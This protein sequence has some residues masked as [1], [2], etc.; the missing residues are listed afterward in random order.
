M[1]TPELREDDGTYE[2]LQK[3]FAHHKKVQFFKTYWDFNKYP[4]GTVL[5]EATNFAMG[6]CKG[7]FCHYIQGDECLHEMDYSEILNNINL[8]RDPEYKNILGLTYK[9][10]HFYSSGN[11]EKYTRKAY[12]REVR[13]I[14]NDLNITSW[15]DA[16]G[17]RLKNGKKLPSMHTNLRTFHYGWARN[18]HQMN[19]KI[20]SMD[21]IFS[22]KKLHEQSKKTVIS[23]T[24]TNNN[25][26]HYDN[27]WGL[28]PFKGSH[29]KVMKT[30]LEDNK[31]KENV[32]NKPFCYQ[33][34]DWRSIL[35][36]Y[37]EKG[38][39]LRPGEFRNYRLQ[40]KRTLELFS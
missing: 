11:I 14:R 17:F 21:E 18:Q 30:W 13:L 3:E 12:R 24:Y 22:N 36:D 16:Q 31:P 19:L 8:L 32:L 39:G 27:I 33:S 10:H 20:A 6:K 23:D 34:G 4:K 25:K 15:L 40:K 5:A 38:T 7:Q 29:P 1:N 2:C 37:F 35:F 28:R 9:F 26:F